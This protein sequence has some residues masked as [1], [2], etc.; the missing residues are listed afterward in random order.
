MAAGSGVT[1]LQSRE[2]TGRTR[3]GGGVR[4]AGAGEFAGARAWPAT[5]RFPVG[6]EAAHGLQ[7]GVC[8]CDRARGPQSGEER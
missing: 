5:V 6:E 2:N 3:A 1:F 7:P 4:L 8:V